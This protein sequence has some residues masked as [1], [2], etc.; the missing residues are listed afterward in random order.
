LDWIGSKIHSKTDRIQPISIENHFKNIIR[1][2]ELQKNPL[3]SKNIDLITEARKLLPELNM[4]ILDQSGYCIYVP[5]SLDTYLKIKNR[6]IDENQLDS[7]DLINYKNHDNPVFLLSEHHLRLLREL[8][9][10]HRCCFKI[11][12]RHTY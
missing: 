6:D 8:F 5:I 4:V 12:Q 10:Y 1:F 3:K 7:R 2:T 9:L 11:L